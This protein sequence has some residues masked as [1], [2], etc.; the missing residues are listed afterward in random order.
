MYNSTIKQKMGECPMCSDGKRKALIG[1]YCN[2]HYW[3]TRR[4]KSAS[5]NSNRDILNEPGLPEL[6]DE[7][8]I[9]FSR[10]V[11]FAAADDNGYIR[12]Y[13]DDAVLRWQDGDAM[14]FIDRDCY[15][16]RWDLRNVKA[17]DRICNR[18][19]DGNLKEFSKKLNLEQ[20]GITDILW[21]EARIPFK[22]TR[23]E[24]RTIILEYSTKFKTLQKQRA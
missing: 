3:Q 1:G 15:F 5:K 24:V 9:V 21:E 8:D 23:E 22:P 7:A 4:M 18:A 10:Y 6:I 12:C 14:H 17:G 16:L 20:P 2:D 19:K 13:I 11:R